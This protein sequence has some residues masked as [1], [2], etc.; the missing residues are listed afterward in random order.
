MLKEMLKLMN[1]TYNHRILNHLKKMQM[2]R[3]YID[4]H[5]Y[6]ENNQ[7]HIDIQLKTEN[8]EIYFVPNYKYFLESTI[9]KNKKQK[10]V[11]KNNKNQEM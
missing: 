8:Q 3:E 1:C 4:I 2:F 7:K 5:E 6:Q 11:N 10:K 9:I